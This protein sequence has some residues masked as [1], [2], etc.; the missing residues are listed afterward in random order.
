MQDLIQ[1]IK[2][3]LKGKQTKYSYYVTYS[4][5]RGFGGHT[6]KTNG[7]IKVGDVG[8]IREFIS[9][10]TKLEGVVVLN[11]KYL[12]IAKDEKPIDKR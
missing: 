12:G 6:I 11:W 2:N 4:Y 1:K 9:N 10:E 3:F 7:S 8:L 5:G